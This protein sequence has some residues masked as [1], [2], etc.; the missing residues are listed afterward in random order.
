MAGGVGEPQA[1][2][3]DRLALLALQIDR[4]MHDQAPAGWRGDEAK[5]RTV[6]NFL[7]P[8]TGKNRDVT[9]RLFE[10]LKNQPGYP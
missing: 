7:Y 3:G 5:E 1:D 2:Y 8:L 6:Q 4:A 10:L 9:A